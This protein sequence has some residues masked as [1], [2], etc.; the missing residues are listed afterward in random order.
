MKFF[1]FL[2]GW[3]KK[4]DERYLDKDF[5]LPTSCN[6]YS[7]LRRQK[8]E[9]TLWYLSVGKQKSLWDFFQRKGRIGPW[10]RSCGRMLG[11]NVRKTQVSASRRGSSS[12]DSSHPVRTGWSEYNIDP[13]VYIY[14]YI[15]VVDIYSM[16]FVLAYLLARVLSARI[17]GVCMGSTA[18]SAR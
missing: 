16:S 12:P 10:A 17:P 9:I 13:S 5:R 11:E 8:S 15:Y 3:L 1:K 4:L 6:V 14:I 2:I 7:Y 18:A